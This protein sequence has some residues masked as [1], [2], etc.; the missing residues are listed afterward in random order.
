MAVWKPLIY[1]SFFRYAFYFLSANE[2]GCDD[3]DDDYTAHVL[4]QNEPSVCS[5]GHAILET[6]S[7]DP[8]RKMEYF[9]IL[10]C[11][12]LAFRVLGYIVLRTVKH[13]HR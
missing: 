10:V 12:L 4:N 11:F 7:I 6:F 9:G 13:V 5:A 1:L 2:L 8:Q 3:D